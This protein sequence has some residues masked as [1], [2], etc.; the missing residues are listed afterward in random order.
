MDK[1]YDEVLVYTMDQAIKFLTNAGM[2][3][4]Y[5]MQIPS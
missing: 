2:Q 4:F 1:L 3:P 5:N